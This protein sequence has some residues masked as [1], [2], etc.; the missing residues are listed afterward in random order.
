MTDVKR[1]EQLKSAKPARLIDIIV[2]AVLSI[3]ALVLS[4]SGIFRGDV[5][6]RVSVT[7]DGEKTEYSL[8]ADREIKLEN[9]TVVI[10][11]GSV[12]VKNSVCPD[13]ICEFMGKISRVNESI[14]CLPSGVI[15]T[16]DG[17]SEF[18]TDTGQQK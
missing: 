16:I 9:L 6:S 18:E 10:E 13:K 8:A 7:V 5:G 3:V 4:L 11:N 17:K 12:Y 2:I 14:V 1:I 15:I